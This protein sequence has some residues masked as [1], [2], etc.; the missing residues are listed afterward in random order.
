VEFSHPEWLVRKWAGRIGIDETAALLEANNRPAPVT[1]RVN[2][3]KT[4]A[5]DLF[6]ALETAGFE[7]R[8]NAL[9]GT[10]MD[11]GR[12]AGLTESEPFRQGLFYIQD[13]AAQTVPPLIR[14]MPGQRV[15]DL[16]A[17]P[18]GKLTAIAEAMAGDGLLIG[19][20]VGT[21]KL[22]R[23]RQ[24]LSRLGVSGVPLVCADAATLA[25]RG[26]FDA[27]L[28]DVP[29]SGLGVLRRRLDLRWRIMPED[30]DRLAGVQAAII[31]NAATLVRPGGLLLYSTCT[32]MPEENEL[33]VERFLERHGE[34]GILRPE[35]PETMLQ[36][37]Y[38]SLW[39]HRHR[40]DGAFAACLR[41]NT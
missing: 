35:A 17:A 20:D 15:L 18:G 11:V 22:A 6:Q 24:N 19:A 39:P 3:L 36:G 23:V 29:C 4:S 41:R 7:P 13:A 37:P 8:R 12:P 33:Q 27:V 38:L 2:R 40:C 30:V 28:A 25:V 32:L 14:F 21:R 16:C 34:F 31:D 1:L 10:A 9:A 26:V 5:D